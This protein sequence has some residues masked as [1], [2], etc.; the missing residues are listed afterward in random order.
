MKKQFLIVFGLA[1]VFFAQTSASAADDKIQAYVSKGKVV[2]TN[3][4]VENT[5]ATLPAAPAPEIPAPVPAVV[6]RGDIPPAINS[7]VNSISKTHGV[8][9]ALVK[10]VMK[11]ESAYNRF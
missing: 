4:V 9:P 2:F 1:A 6:R 11:T 5:P 8:D 7:L 10:A 3:L